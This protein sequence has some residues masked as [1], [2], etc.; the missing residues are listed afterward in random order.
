MSRRARLASPLALCLVAAA[1]PA[2]AAPEVVVSI[3]PLHSLVARVMQGVGEPV[4]LVGGGASLHSYSLKPSQAAALESADLVVWIG[5]GFERFLAQPLEA[6]AADA[7]R[8]EALELPGM[9]L[10]APREGGAWE[11]HDLDHG[12][13]HA[14]GE[15]PDLQEEHAEHA[16]HESE[17]HEAHAHEEGGV[18][19]HLFL[20]PGN[21]AVL[22]EAVALALAALDPAQGAAYAANAAAL[23]REL[24]ALDAEIAATLA[25]V[26]ARRFVV[27]HDAYQY[28]E[29]HYGLAAIGSIVVSPEQPPGVRRLAEIRDKIAALGATCVFAEPGFEPALVETVIAGTG[30]RSGVLDPEGAALEPGPDMYGA[31][32]RGLAADLVAC[33][34]VSG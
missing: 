9:V 31:L 20:D 8:V 23:R 15:E 19:G 2:E 29:A 24:A 16:E 28:F 18:D 13:E 10:R 30:A 1:L 34:A 17:E 26:R 6:L 33:L 14:E 3:K 22:A 32:L 11:L 21:A 12:Q 5:P 25:P 4:L 7:V 27:F